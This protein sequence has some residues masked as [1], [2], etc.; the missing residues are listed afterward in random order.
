MCNTI[1]LIIL[2]IGFIL[3][4]AMSICIGTSPTYINNPEARKDLIEHM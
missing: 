2:I 3:A 1:T 4:I